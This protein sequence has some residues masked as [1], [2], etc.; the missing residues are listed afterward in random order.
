MTDMEILSEIFREAALVPVCEENKKQVVELIERAKLP[1]GKEQEYRVKIQNLP[2]D[3]LAIDLDRNF[4]VDCIFSGTKGECRRADYIIVSEAEKCIVYIEMKYGTDKL[5]GIVEQLSGAQCFMKYCQEIARV[6]WKA[7]GN[8]L[9]GYK[10][11]FISFKH[12]GSINKKPGKDTPKRGRHDIPGNPLVLSYT[13][14]IQFP[15]LV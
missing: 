9:Y 13:P 14:K 15:V 6:F 8:F 10:S 3:A 2:S 12:C 11:R 4:H 7:G 5:K 1:G